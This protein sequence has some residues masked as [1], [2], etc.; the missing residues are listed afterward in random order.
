MQIPILIIYGKVVTD[1]KLS[2][3]VHMI[4]MNIN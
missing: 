3:L 2:I 1:V 4:I